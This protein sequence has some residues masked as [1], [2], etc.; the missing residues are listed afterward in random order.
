MTT[1][2]TQD[3]SAKESTNPVGD[4]RKLTVTGNVEVGNTNITPTLKVADTIPIND[5]ILML[6]L[7]LDPIG[8]G[9]TVMTWK[10]AKY[11][12]AI[13]EDQYESVEVH[14]D[15][16]LV[17]RIAVVKVHSVNA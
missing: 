15:G 6:E 13:S 7:S 12:Q 10:K 4:D 1:P 5:R 8:I 2:N 3:W 14:H 16:D 11:E 9:N 17:E